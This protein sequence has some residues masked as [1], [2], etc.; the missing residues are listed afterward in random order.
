MF[1]WW[2]VLS[3]F[4]WLAWPLLFPLLRGL[5]DRGYGLARAA[6]W[7]L[8]GWV[9]WIGVSLGWWQNRLGPSPR[10]LASLAVAGLAAGVAQRR[11]LAAFWRERRRLLLGEEALFAR[12]L[13][14]LRRR[15]PAQPGPVAAVERRREVHGVRLPE[16]DPAQPALPALRPVLC[17]RDVNY[18]YY[19]LYLVSLPIKLTGIVLRSR[20]TWR[21]RPVCA[22]GAGPVQRWVFVGR[23]AGA[24]WRMPDRSQRKVVETQRW[25][26]EPS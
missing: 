8:V 5:R 17:R 6:G 24:G 10:S 14:G 19:G 1:F 25:Q 9:H 23:G 2:L 16:R 26:A 12:G 20:S 15:P 22:D 3:L 4:G 18:Y 11:R 21:S 13:P 7:L